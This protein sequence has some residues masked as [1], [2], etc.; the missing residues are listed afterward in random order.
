MNHEMHFFLTCMRCN[1]KCLGSRR[2]P[3]CSEARLQ[4]WQERRTALSERPLPD[5]EHNNTLRLCHQLHCSL[6]NKVP[7][8]HL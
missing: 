1:L 6:R 8:S 4:D 3:K 5:P 2:S 7:H